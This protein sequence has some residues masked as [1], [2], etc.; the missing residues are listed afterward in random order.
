MRYIVLV[1]S[2]YNC[3]LNG[4]EVGVDRL[5]QDPI[6][7]QLKG[8]KI[9]LITNHTGKNSKC[10]STIEIFAQDPN[11]HLVALFSP[12]HGLFGVA[13][14]GEKVYSTHQRSIPVHSLHGATRRPTPEML[15][16]IDVLVYDIQ[17]AGVRAYTYAS[18]L[19]YVMEEAAKLHLPV[20]VLDRPN[21]ISGD[22]VD[23]MLL[24]EKHWR[25]F[26]GYVNVPYCHGMTIGELA[27]F[28]KEEYHISCDIFV[29]KMQGWHRSMS[30]C[31]TQ[32]P[33]IPTSPNVPEAMTPL[34]MATT[35]LLGE[36]GIV[37]IGIGY[38][39]PFKVVGAP[40]I[41]EQKFADHL[42]KQKLPGVIFIPFHYRPFFGL[43]KGEQ[44][45]GVLIQ[46][47]SL[48][49]YKPVQVQCLLLGSLKSL[50]PKEIKKYLRQ[51][52]QTNKE[53]FCKTFGSDFALKALEK[54]PYV[55]WKLIDK[56]QQ[57]SHQFLDV[58][59]KY[60]FPEYQ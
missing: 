20:V 1:I 44:C 11:C 19:Y 15:K 40:W 33:W 17:D 18:T 25:S 31:D 6:Y 42:N 22:I 54:E 56:C 14:A 4:L 48:Q 9:G 41:N 50:Y 59:K 24:D 34:Y 32:L 39:L 57:D 12:E 7:Q 35:G 23:G 45:N 29:V 27:M 52:K 21:P 47:S 10:V 13:Y 30:Y 26:I 5:M 28:F 60:L 36:L 55:A 49:D 53:A 37:N 46:V 38:T 3:L 43:F 2:L 16:G 58:R 51:L 8:K